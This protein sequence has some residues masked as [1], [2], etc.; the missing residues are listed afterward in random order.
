MDHYFCL[1]FVTA[2]KYV[3]W[4]LDDCGLKNRKTKWKEFFKKVSNS[5]SP[6]SKIRDAS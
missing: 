5:Q 3:I 1:F 2:R 6:G 4:N